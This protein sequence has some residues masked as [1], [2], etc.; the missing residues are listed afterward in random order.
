[1]KNVTVSIITNSVDE[2][3]ALG[4]RIGTVLKGG[5]TFELHSDV[6][7][8]KTSFIKGVAE[9]MGYDDTVQSPTFVVGTIYDMPTDLQLHHYDFYRL[10]DPGIM[11]EQLAES[12]AN[13]KAVVAVEWG[14][15][16]E[17]VLPDEVIKLTAQADAFDEALRHFTFEIPEKYAY[18]TEA[19]TA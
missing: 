2:T 13:S 9:G 15:V 19:I 16:V 17:D 1:M 10:E 6:G 11:R 18:L 14:G 12:L 7:G 5:E 8:G 4:R 3:L